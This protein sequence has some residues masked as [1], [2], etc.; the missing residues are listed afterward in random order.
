MQ[1]LDNQKR[2]EK[3]TLSQIAN[4]DQLFLSHRNRLN[5]DAYSEQRLIAVLSLLAQLLKAIDEATDIKHQ[6]T[7]HTCTQEEVVR[8]VFFANLEHLL[9]R[10]ENELLH[11]LVLRGSKAINDCGVYWQQYQANREKNWFHEYPD[12]LPPLSTTWPWSIKPSLAVIWGV[13]WMFYGEHNNFTSDQN[14]ANQDASMH[15]DFGNYQALWYL[16]EQ[17][18]SSEVFTCLMVP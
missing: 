1:K 17:S 11:A 16:S 10:L 5:L 2:K 6:D 7:E 9:F 3:Y 13:C 18:F 15:D 14:S 12:G 8:L 4:D